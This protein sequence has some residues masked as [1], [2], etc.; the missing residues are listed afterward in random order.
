VRV[1]RLTPSLTGVAVFALGVGSL[2]ALRAQ[3]PTSWI[4]DA[5]VSALTQMQTLNSGGAGLQF[6]DDHSGVLGGLLD[7]R[8]TFTQDVTLAAGVTYVFIVGGDQGVRT[9]DLLLRDAH[10]AVVAHDTEADA[11][12]FVTVRPPAAAVYRVQLRFNATHRHA[13]AYFVVLILTK[14]T[15]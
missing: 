2:Q 12:P 15:S 4:V 1:R 8:G 11:T 9:A 3:G 10:G 6:A 5:L 13:K 7:E 14:P